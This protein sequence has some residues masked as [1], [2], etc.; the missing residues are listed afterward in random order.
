[1]KTDESGGR[2]YMCGGVGCGRV[3]FSGIGVTFR[4][5]SV[6]GDPGVSHTG[7]ASGLEAVLVWV[8]LQSMLLAGGGLYLPLMMAGLA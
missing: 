3:D 1:M 7:Q 5:N 6:L 8:L 4:G 2:G